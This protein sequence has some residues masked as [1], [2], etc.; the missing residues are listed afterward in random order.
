M[1]CAISAEYVS[2]ICETP[3][4]PHGG[5]HFTCIGQ[6]TFVIPV[7]KLQVPLC[8]IQNE[9]VKSL[10]LV[11]QPVLS[12]NQPLPVNLPNGMPYVISFIKD[13]SDPLVL[14]RRLVPLVS[15]VPV[16]SMSSSRRSVRGIEPAANVEA[17]KKY[18]KNNTNMAQEKNLGKTIIEIDKKN[19]SKPYLS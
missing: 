9:T 14:I 6:A 8:C 17:T 10:L 2:C 11:A 4:E 19:R 18:E 13:N 1:V 15:R 5:Y 16:A 12:L 3:Q 7:R